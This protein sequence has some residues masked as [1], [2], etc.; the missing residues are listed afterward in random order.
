MNGIDSTLS[1]IYRASGV[2]STTYLDMFKICEKGDIIKYLQEDS[3]YEHFV[4]NRNPVYGIFPLSLFDI[5]LVIIKEEMG[6]NY[7]YSSDLF[8]HD[9]YD[10]E[11]IQGIKSF[12]DV[13][14]A[15]LSK[16]LEKNREK[17]L[18]DP[19]CEPIK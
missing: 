17:N 2:L 7:Y 16:E 6:C 19:N 1:F 13:A 5:P 8:L 14:I 18:M 11:K 15:F 9:L 10:K 3:V 12:M 4:G